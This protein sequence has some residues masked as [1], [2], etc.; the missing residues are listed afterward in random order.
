MNDGTLNE[1][2]DPPRECIANK[3]EQRK[4]FYYEIAHTYRLEVIS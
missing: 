2:I 1:R 3:R 4:F